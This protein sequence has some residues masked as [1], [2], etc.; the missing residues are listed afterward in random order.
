MTHGQKEMNDYDEYRLV[1]E[2]F[3]YPNFLH[4]DK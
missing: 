3:L 1:L 2:D 4:F